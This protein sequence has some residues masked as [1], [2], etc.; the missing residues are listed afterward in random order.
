MICDTC[1]K[2]VGKSIHPVNGKMYCDACCPECNSV[3]ETS[4]GRRQ[5]RLWLA[6]VVLL[7]LALLGTCFTAAVNAA[8]DAP[9]EYVAMAL[10][11]RNTD[12]LSVVEVSAA[13]EVLA[14]V[15]YW[16]DWQYPP[17]VQDWH[18]LPDSGWIETKA[19][20]IAIWSPDG[21]VF[22]ARLLGQTYRVRM[23]L[24]F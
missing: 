4:R 11:P 24:I 13:P 10:C 23:P 6:I 2:V 22:E 15:M 3:V 17:D 16:E 12:C 5:V 18:P 1:G 14:Q 7:C 21:M 19:L 9:G 20:G 8:P